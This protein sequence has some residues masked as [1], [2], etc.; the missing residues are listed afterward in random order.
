[1]GKK[2]ITSQS[3]EELLKEREGIEA[4]TSQASTG[5]SAQKKVRGGNIYIYSSY[6]NTMMTLTD[7][8]GNALAQV[9]AGKIGFKG[10]KKSTPF[11]ASK[12]A[13]TLSQIAEN[14]GIN[15]I[16]IYIKGVG[17][18][19]DSALRSFAAREFELTGI[20]DAT[21]IPHN[22]PRARKIRRP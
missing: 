7:E 22:G 14:K 13:E 19:R 16:K 9:S 4:R 5:K 8:E 20:I 12:V 17:P 2:R 21:P 6:N 18:G 10:A 11:A 3:Q 15:R 1:M